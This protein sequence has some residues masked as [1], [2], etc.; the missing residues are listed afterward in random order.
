MNPGRV[1]A[2]VVLLMTHHLSTHAQDKRAE[3]PLDPQSQAFIAASALQNTPRWDEISIED[4]RRGFNGLQQLFGSGPL[5]VNTVNQKLDSR[6]PVRIYKPAV[7][8]ADDP[9]LPVVVFFHGGGWVLG[10]LET[11]DALC[12]RLCHES[13]CAV[14]S[15]DY[16]LA[17]EHPFPAPLDDCY[18]ATAYVSEHAKELGV[19]AS[20]LVV[21]GDSAGGNLA[22]AVAIRARDKSGPKIL[23]Q[24][25]IYPVLDD[26]CE[27][28]SYKA[29]AT[30]HGL[31]RDDMLWFWK[32]Y[33]GGKSH[34]AYTSPA[35]V[36]SA[37]GLPKAFLVTAQ[38]DV[39]RDEGEAYADKLRTAGVEVEMHRYEGML[40]GF[41]HFANAFDKSK[42]ATTEIAKKIKDFV[43]R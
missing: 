24:I 2:I 26:R 33:T 43:S 5:E 20:K 37:E 1:F 3:P 34:G 36:H 15:V 17:P 27:S 7:S 21:A 40:H 39:L 32:Q 28:T 4:A 11:H 38:Y 35:A 22:A 41:I 30:K 8:R 23:A 25:L 12:R 31:S 42:E 18:N 16:R 13:K 14:V 10:N 6:I 19:D 29:Y 9:L